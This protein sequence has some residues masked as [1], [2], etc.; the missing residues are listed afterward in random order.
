VEAGLVIMFLSLPVAISGIQT[1]LGIAAAGAAWELVRGRP[2]PRTALDEPILVLLGLTVLSAVLSAHPL[3]SIGRLRSAWLMVPCYLVVGWLGSPGRLRRFLDVLFWPAIVMGVYGIVQHY[4]GWNLLR[5]G[6]KTLHSLL[7][8][9]R[10]VYF[11]RGGF[12]HYQTYANVFYLIFC[13]SISLAAGSE[14]RAARLRWGGAVMLF[15]AVLVLSYTRGIWL[16]MVTAVAIFGLLYLKRVKLFLGATLGVV[17]LVAVLSP[18]A[19]LT[20]VRSMGQLD[21]NVERLL[22]WETTWNMLRDHPVLGVGVGNYRDAQDAYIRE[23]VSLP[24]TRTHAHNIWLQIAAER[25]VLGLLA[26][27]WLTVAIFKEAISGLHRLR[28]GG[29]IRFALLAGGLAGITGFYLDGLF[30]NNFGDSVAATLFW[31]VVGIIL[32]CSRADGGGAAAT[33]EGTA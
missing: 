26:F 8:A 24:M 14:T 21:T 15:S 16:S 12:S 29:G 10:L 30:Q 19:L 2:F 33:T 9:D 25:G 17:L 27:F 11:P 1:G 23:E 4:T 13:L 18:S 7:L 20:R 32:V 28:A 31:V 3:Q 22:L 6:S 5:S